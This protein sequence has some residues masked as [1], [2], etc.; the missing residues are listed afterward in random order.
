MSH[1][2]HLT[3]SGGQL[4]SAAVWL[5]MLFSLLSLEASELKR[6]E[7]DAGRSRSGA[8]VVSGAVLLHTAQLLSLDEH[9][10]ILYAGDTYKQ[11]ETVFDMLDKVLKAA[12][13]K[14]ESVVKLNVYVANDEVGAEVRMEIRRR[15]GKNLPAVSYMRGHLMHGEALVALDAVAVATRKMDKVESLAINGIHPVPGGSHV[16]FLPAGRKAYVS[17]MASKGT[18]A[19]ATD[20][21]MKQLWSVLE[22]LKAEPAQVVQLKAFLNPMTDYGVV[23]EEIKKRFPAGNLPVVHLVEW[24]STTP[25]EIELI[26]ALPKSEE[27]LPVVEYLTPSGV[28]ASPVYSRVVRVNGGKDVY[29]SGLFG[30]AATNGEGQLVAIFGELRR[31]A[32]AAGSDLRHLV[33]ATYYVASDDT[34]RRLNTIRPDYYDP[35]RPPAASKASVRGVGL[36]GRTVTLDMIAVTKE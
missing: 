32:E 10:K 9:G 18:M 1:W 11:T 21:T 34:N 6:V 27:K 13:G 20:E 33:K 31:L 16:T 17:G 22:F 35:A 4:K 15:F 5:I 8:V 3:S 14:R 28:T 30:E 36:A 29:V 12:H 26:V 19:V 25:I 24:T 2:K 7:V 23:L